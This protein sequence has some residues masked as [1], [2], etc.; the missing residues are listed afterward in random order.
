MSEYMLNDQAAINNINPFVEFD[1]S[2][3]G[4]WSKPP[5][6]GVM[7]KE[8]PEVE[9]EEESP[10]CD[11]GIT[12]GDRTI[13]WCRRPKPNCPLNRMWEPQRLWDSE[14]YYKGEEE[15]AVR[16]SPGIEKDLLI[17]L[18]YLFVFYIILDMAR[19]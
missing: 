6:Y 18:V 3:P 7:D 13:D 10:A 9:E 11:L 5:T 17:I 15:P 19:R 4:A 14:F 2:L 16:P 1:F 8:T 12:A